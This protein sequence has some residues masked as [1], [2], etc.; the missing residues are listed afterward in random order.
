[1]PFDDD[2][3]L[4]GEYSSALVDVDASD[5]VSTSLTVNTD[6]N[7][8][9]DL[10]KTGMS[11]P[12]SAVLILTEEADANAYD[13]EMTVT[14]EESEFL[15]R[16]WQTVATFPVF[17]CHIRKV[18][19]TATTAFVA[20]DIGQD[21][22]ETTS[23]DTGKILF[24]STG[25]LTT[26]ANGG[27]VLVEMDAAGDLFDE[28]VGTVETSGGTGVGTK[29]AASTAGLE[30]QMQPGIYVRR[31]QSHKRYVRGN[32]GTPG[33]NFG[34]CWLLLSNAYASHNSDLGG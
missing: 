11:N 12:L 29:A 27:Y 22:T 13:D 26:G 24:V 21:L 6:G 5:A 18:P 30:L 14:I 20:A 33:G 19:I 28:A 2:L 3:I 9:V 34:K 17:H 25:L 15:D 31:F 16:S 32:F 23:N 4:K 7:V 8:C 1:M 10:K